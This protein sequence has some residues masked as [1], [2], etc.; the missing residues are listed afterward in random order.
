MAM[1]TYDETE[2]Y[3][4]KSATKDIYVS[5]VS[6][7]GQGGSFII[8]KDLKPI[9]ANEKTLIGKASSND[10]KT[11]QVIVTIQDKLEQTNWTGAHVIISEGDE[12][13]IYSYAQELPADKDIA[14]YNVTIKMTK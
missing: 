7:N 1:Y 5:V 11:V 10:G 4:L 13:T 9:G 3:K 6:G 2:E 14:C 12:N 8:L